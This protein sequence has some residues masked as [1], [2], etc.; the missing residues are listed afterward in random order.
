MH[1]EIIDSHNLKR[2][3]KKCSPETLNLFQ[4]LLTENIRSSIIRM[5]LPSNCIEVVKT[6]IQSAWFQ[7][8]YDIDVSIQVITFPRPEFLFIQRPM[9]C[10]NL[11]K[12]GGKTSCLCI[13]NFYRSFISPRSIFRRE[14][15]LWISSGLLFDPQE[16]ET[17]YD[18][19][20]GRCNEKG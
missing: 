2:K 3:F 6:H 17:W 10:Q 14:N 4:V 7:Q 8:T 11:E 18:R 16:T 20:Q 9:L 13:R 12:S 19:E 1:D 5:L 15:E